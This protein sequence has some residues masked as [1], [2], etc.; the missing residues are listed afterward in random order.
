MAVWLIIHIFHTCE[1]NALEIQIK[2]FWQ[3]YS[4][5]DRSGSLKVI[6]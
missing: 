3:V 5:L 1:E 6:S 4:L 2:M